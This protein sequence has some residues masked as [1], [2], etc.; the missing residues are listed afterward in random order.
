[1]GDGHHMGV[2]ALATRPRERGLEGLEGLGHVPAGR[3]L[4]EEG[5]VVAR[6]RGG[7]RGGGP[8][9]VVVWEVAEEAVGEAADAAAAVD[10]VLG[11]RLR[12]ARPAR[13]ASKRRTPARP[14]GS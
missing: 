7:G 2:F 4:P 3:R 11:A 13:R 14:R 5:A 12:A 9:V 10:V 6:R 8:R 1:M